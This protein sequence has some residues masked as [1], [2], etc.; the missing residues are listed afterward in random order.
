MAA[1]RQSTPTFDPTKA[2]AAGDTTRDGSGGGDVA[3]AGTFYSKPTELAIGGASDVADTI[4]VSDGLLGTLTFEVSNATDEEV[5]KGTDDDWHKDPDV[6]DVSITG[7]GIYDIKA[8]RI[9]YGR[10]RLKLVATHSGKVHSRRV[11]KFS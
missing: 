3:G 11:C 10:M 4:V 1:G 7:D 9:P 5:F 2:A 6:A 8:A